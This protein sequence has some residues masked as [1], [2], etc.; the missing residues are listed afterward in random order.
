MKMQRQRIGK[1]VTMDSSIS[2][3]L[4]RSYVI[5]ALVLLI[6]H[7]AMAAEVTKSSFT[8]GESVLIR[9]TPGATGLTILFGDQTYRFLGEPDATI[10]FQPSTPGVYLIEETISDGAII[11]T[12]FEI[13]APDTTLPVGG[14]PILTPTTPSLENE[15]AVISGVPT[16]GAIDT[17]VGP[18]DRSAA[19]DL[20]RDERPLGALN[21]GVR[22]R[23]GRGTGIAAAFNIRPE[24]GGLIKGSTADLGARLPT[25]GKA[26][27]T[28]DLPDR[29]VTRVQLRGVDLAKGIDLGVDDIPEGFVDIP[30]PERRWTTV[31][32]IDP[33]NLSFTDGELRAVATGTALHKCVSW[34]FASRT[35][36]GSWV[37]IMDLTPGEEYVVGL[38]PVDPGFGES[39]IATGHG[40]ISDL[41]D[42][43]VAGSVPSPLETGANEWG[44]VVFNPTNRTI[45]ITGIQFSASASIIGGA[46]GV[47][48]ATTWGSALNRVNWSG[49]VILGPQDAAEFIVN[50]QGRSVNLANVNVEVNATTNDTNLVADGYQ[51]YTRNAAIQYPSLYLANASG[52]ATF[53]STN[54]SP[55]GA[56]SFIVTVDNGAGASAVSLATGLVIYVPP[57]WRDVDAGAQAGWTVGTILGDEGAG[58]VLI[59]QVASTTIAAGAARNFTFTATPPD[60]DEDRLYRLYGLLLGPASNANIAVTSTLIPALRVRNLSTPLLDANDDR[61]ATT[62]TIGGSRKVDQYLSVPAP[63]DS[64][65]TST[66]GA[67]IVNPTDEPINVT[68]LDF[69]TS[70]NVFSAVAA[71]HPAA[72]WSV[73]SA[74]DVR[75]T[76][77]EQIPPRSALSF[78]VNIS[79]TAA[80]TLVTTVTLTSAT[81]A[82]TLV[83][84]GFVT[85]MST[86]NIQYP[87]LFAVNTTGPTFV[88][89]NLSPKRTEQIRIRV[90][91]RGASATIPVG[92][93][94]EVYTPAGWTNLTAE[95]QTGWTIAHVRSDDTGGGIIRATTATSTIATGASR[96]FVFNITPPSVG[97]NSTYRF[98]AWLFGE[99]GQTTT[100]IMQSTLQ[101]AARVTPGTYGIDFNRSSDVFTSIS[102][103]SSVAVN[104]IVKANKSAEFNL[105]IRN[106][107]TGVFE[108][109][110]A[111]ILG[112]AEEDWNAT[113]RINRT[114]DP[115]DYVNTSTGRALIRWLSTTSNVTALHEDY[116]TI[117]VT[118]DTTSPVINLTS[119][120]NNTYL[121]VTSVEFSINAS[122]NTDLRNCTI[123][124]NGTAN[125]TNTTPNNATP[126]T[127]SIS[128]FTNGV[129]LWSASCSDLNGHRNATRNWTFTI[130][131]I[132]P[133]VNLTSP[134]NL[135]RYTTP[136]V[137]FTIMPNDTNLANCS[138]IING[139]V[140]QTNTTPVS[141]APVNFTVDLPDGNTTWTAEC[142]DLARNTLR[143]SSI[144]TVRVDTRAPTY[145]AIVVSPP[146]GSVYN[147]SQRYLFSVN[148]S[149][150]NGLFTVIFESNV[151]GTLANLTPNHVVGT[152][153]T[154][155]FTTLPAGSF[156]WRMYA[157]DTFGNMNL[158]SQ[159]TYVIMKASS[160]VTLLLNGTAENYP[161][162]VNETVN[163]TGI[164]NTPIVGQLEIHINGAWYANGSTPLQ[165]ITS[166]LTNGSRNVTLHYNE[167]QN[168][169]ASNVTL[170]IPV[171]DKLGPS[172]NKTYPRNNSFVNAVNITFLF[173]IT[174]ATGVDNCTLLINGTVN[175]TKTSG[176][177]N[178]APNNI[179]GG[180]FEEA[181]YIWA[182]RCVDPNGNNATGSNFTFT[183]D[184]TLP[185]AFALLTPANDTVS[186]QTQ[187]TLSWAASSDLH[188]SN[189]SLLI[190][191]AVDFSS[192]NY[193]YTLEPVSNTSYTIPDVLASGTVWNWQVI[194]YDL[195]GNARVSD[196][197]FT[198]IVDTDAPAITLQTPSDGAYLNTTTFE[199]TY[200]VTDI[201][202]VVYCNITWNDTTTQTNTT[203]NQSGFNLFPV[204]RIEGVH[205]FTITCEDE[206]A[207]L[208]TSS[209]RTVTIDITSPLAVTL[210]SPA[211]GTFSNVNTPLLVWTQSADANFANYTVL[212]SDDTLFPHHNYTYL[213]SAVSTL[214]Y[215]V[216]TPWT[217]GTWWWKVLVYD[218]AGNWVDP[219]FSYTV[220]STPP[221]V[222]TLLTPMNNTASTNRTPTLVWEESADINFANYTVL[223]SNV[224]DMS[225]VSFSYTLVN[226]SN[227]TLNV[228]S[229]WTDN[230]IWYWRVVAR[231]NATNSRNSTDTY[232]Y[233][234]DNQAPTLTLLSPANG[235]TIQTNSSLI[236]FVYNITDLSGVASCV[237]AINDSTS[238]V[239]EDEDVFVDMDMNQ[240][241]I[242]S[243][244]TG[245]YNWSISCTD[246]AGNNVTSAQRMLT[247]NVT[248]PKGSWYDSDG[249]SSPQ[250]NASMN[251]SAIA[252][253]VN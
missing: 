185:A 109:V 234:T 112:T 17:V 223:V 247:V 230:T 245:D 213:V 227:T 55:A 168:Y 215:Q 28:F 194:A 184:R 62:W 99:T 165:N 115:R 68:Q 188:F 71:I 158:T 211:N 246:L 8:V 149:D 46:T 159:Q 129:Y 7:S 93:Q 90:S 199:V 154:Y 21:S 224:P 51:T 5:L 189:Y 108:T 141:G 206:A 117:N 95:T 225:V 179:T 169:T 65:A 87:S 45:Q 84:T 20:E 79:A 2:S 119:P 228:P 24:E 133:R 200:L 25:S 164:L 222:F 202:T 235:V 116:L 29:H 48:P 76:G 56:E 58:W 174:D 173:N 35:C 104:D 75:W 241:F 53:L 151:T 42:M 167:T 148:W 47:V 198:Y 163:I 92:T 59:P 210:V 221:A 15:T 142:T 233:I 220:D 150:A 102:N 192:P 162:D 86:G 107:R 197:P 16:D 54:L 152:N 127:L 94:L 40:G 96:D 4:L 72:T 52:R 114:S 26:E 153:Y 43:S 177:V 106:V 205:N 144:R 122:D 218:L 170:R 11:R 36:P 232:R 190:D 120:I 191:N 238:T 38:S 134:A 31:Y 89:T 69:Q 178:D 125:Q 30:L 186:T 251:T 41:T 204:T 82:G 103:I 83:S 240:T 12:Q 137:V 136:S 214:S 6:A 193:I 155:N 208:A 139:L 88:L 160:N 27:V 244:S 172:M 100:Q 207:N 66:W 135:T 121:N 124:I 23:T 44:A 132:L 1:G 249:S 98:D 147:A 195:A 239:F 140:N 253:Y 126:T 161:V 123:F 130:D 63:F 39:V 146:S 143:N 74:S 118:Y 9:T 33:T 145:D 14:A 242:E 113:W 182:L 101:F 138:I 219:G 57:G 10:A 49:S 229:P 32:A 3:L 187:P 34:D 236:T 67:A 196:A 181:T 180:P 91:N 77:N 252:V 18:R 13:L 128:G 157:N 176:L 237:I 78:A 105:S 250:Q 216:I 201:S 212:V 226:A 80:S 166:F 243:L 248:I 171:G 203:I 183:V 22:I 217:D 19:Q 111:A 231:D 50:V 60:R 70:S 209:T 156:V 81:T 131:T 37:K 175:A 97:T 64:V 73:A 110:R 61:Y 85:S